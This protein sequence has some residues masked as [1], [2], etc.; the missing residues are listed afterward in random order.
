[1]IG[2]TDGRDGGGRVVQGSAAMDSRVV[3]ASALLGRRSADPVDRALRDEI[4]LCNARFES[5]PAGDVVAWAVERFGTGLVLSCS[6]QESV[7]I[8]LAVRVQPDIAIVF[9]DTGS[10]FDET[11]SFVE[12]IRQRY[13]L[14]LTV[15]QPIPGAEAHPCGSAHC[16]E[17]RKVR[18]LRAALEGRQAWMTGLKRSDAPTRRLSPIVSY[19]DVFDVVKINPLATWT[20]EDLLRYARAHGIPEH[21]LRANGYVSIGCA[22]T[23]QPV[24]DGEHPRAGR[25]SDTD[26]IE[27]GLHP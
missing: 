15:T 20:H 9:L 24:T 22:P 19:D 10:H 5:T 7:L 11:L 27:C 21:P 12:A 1:M 16:C 18:P 6:F 3:D 25:W 17:F 26:R 13:D 14:N 4:A 23:T 8:D 2:H